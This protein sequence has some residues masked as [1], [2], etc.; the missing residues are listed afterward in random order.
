MFKSKYLFT[1]LVGFVDGGFATND[2]TNLDFSWAP[3]PDKNSPIFSTGL[4]LRVNLFGYAVL[5][6]YA[7]IPFQREDK[8]ITFGLFIRGSGW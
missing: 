1:T 5:E 8:D 6:P 3:N 2:Y 4:A 7:A